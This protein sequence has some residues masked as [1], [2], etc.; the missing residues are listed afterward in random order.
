MRRHLANRKTVLHISLVAAVSVIWLAYRT[1]RKPSRINYPC[2]RAAVANLQVFLVA[3]AVPPL[4]LRRWLSALPRLL[5]SKSG[6]SLLVVGCILLASSYATLTSL[7]TSNRVDGLLPVELDLRSRTALAVSDSSSLFFV[8]NAAGAEGNMDGA[9]SA[10]MSVMESKG[11]YLYKTSSQPVGLIAK[12]DV[13]LI[14]VNAVGPER[15]GTNTDL[16]KSLINKI[17]NHPEGFTGEVIVADNGQGT[18]GLNLAE[19]NAYDHSQSFQDVANMFPS[20]KVSAWSLYTVRSHSVEE[21]DRG[22]MDDGYVV[23]ATENA[24][25]G[26]R[27]SYPKFRTKYGTYISFKEGIW[28]TTTSS[29]NPDRLKVINFPVLK[30]HYDYGVTACMKNYMGVQS[31][32][33][34]NMHDLMKYGAAGTEMAETRFPTLNVLDA[35]WV[36]AN[37]VESGPD[38]G[39]PT[40]YDVASYTNTI[41]AS[42][43]PVALEYWA[44]KHILVPAAKNKGY[45]QY[46]SLDPD[47]EAVT[48]QLTE[49]YHTYLLNS[50]NELRKRGY[51]A[52]MSEDNMNVY[53]TSPVAAL[54]GDGFESGSFNDWSG[55]RVAIE[56]DTASIASERF[57]HG[58][59]SAVF[60]TGGGEGYEWAYCYTT[61]ASASELYARGNFYVSQSGVTADN[62]RSYFI[63][64]RSS[65]ENVAYAG[66]RKSAGAVRWCLTLR[67]GSSFVDLYSS[68]GL[69]TGRWYSIELHWKEGFSKGFA[70][71]LVDGKV[72]C[73]SEDINS[74]AFGD[75]QRVLFGLAEVKA[76]ATTVYL[77]CAEVSLRYIGPEPA[78]KVSSL[79]IFLSS[80]STTSR[81]GTTISGYLSSG[82]AG[83]DILIK[84]RA[85]PGSYGFWTTVATVSTDESGEYTYEWFPRAAASY[86][87]KA[88]WA[89]DA[90]SLP[91]DSPVVE[92]ICSYVSTSISIST[93]SSTSLSDLKVNITGTLDELDG[94]PLNGEAVTVYSAFNGTA[95]WSEIGQASKTDSSGA[96]SKT[97]APPASGYYVL[98]AEWAGNAT[99]SPASSKTTLSEVS[100]SN[101]YVFTVESNSS[102]SGLSYDEA[103]QSVRF[104]VE[105][106]SGTKGYAQITVPKS[107]AVDTAKMMVYVDDSETSFETSSRDG[108][109]V[110]AIEYTH[111]EHRVVVDLDFTPVPEYPALIVMP[112]LMVM[113]LLA[114]VASRKTRAHRD[115]ATT[116]P[117][118][119][120]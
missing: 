6:R 115:E 9:F 39:P 23:N 61:V 4:D 80:N 21:Y 2:Q 24:V 105:G 49:S 34:S 27:V 103:N 117:L 119:P 89:G 95:D 85:V 3:L 106:P 87:V 22:D 84:V 108:S 16:V 101:Q 47:Y 51:Q 5:R 88:S 65:T 54:F 120:C 91:A 94:A 99:H 107:L 59:Y 74:G 55:T 86:E 112:L 1:G 71:M 79:S 78:D 114:V 93:S 28:S 77:D 18:G 104:S 42:T 97:W 63:V 29:Y 102:T 73:N 110:L 67:D 45:T 46:S 32:D 90:Q 72:V 75:V 38:C 48:P 8:Q 98:K 83:S 70:E 25:T 37:P 57:H 20:Y 81:A 76:G 44:A 40:S 33:L 11:L 50:M 62:D 35:I 15:S 109:W 52:T 30:S 60:A 69:L 13:V 68:P 66:W 64:F 53:T 100:F 56:G 14:K 26:L 10:L 31:Q 43:D 41:G 116:Y 19:S 12:G 58:A 92:L 36:N 118:S 96:Y 111:S 82:E 17:V 7:S 113:L